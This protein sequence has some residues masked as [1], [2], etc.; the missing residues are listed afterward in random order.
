[1][2][3][4]L[5]MK[6]CC[7][8]LLLVVCVYLS[9]CQPQFTETRI[10]NPSSSLLNALMQ[11]RDFSNESRWIDNSVQQQPEMP[12]TENNHLVESA[13][14]S[15]AGPYGPKAYY[16]SVFHVLKRYE[17]QPPFPED[18]NLKRDWEAV[19]VQT[20]SPKVVSVGQSM[21]SECL[22]SPGDQKHAIVA[23]VVSAR[24]SHVVST[25]TLSADAKIDD[26]TVENV[27]N[28]ILMKV[29]SRIKEIDK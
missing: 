27:L 1:M 6:A 21:V 11:D 22:K 26:Q 29:D 16:I 12:T 25:L 2:L 18:I 8:I 19:D 13:L 28:Q 23:C 17:Q 9:A 7:S 15:L 20:F 10:A 14:R 5:C 3:K 4:V 24:Y